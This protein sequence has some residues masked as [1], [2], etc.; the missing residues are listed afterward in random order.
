MYFYIPIKKHMTIKKSG[1]GAQGAT[2]TTE[3]KSNGAKPELSNL[4]V[5]PKVEEPK[6][7]A[8]KEE[9][10]KPEQPQKVVSVEDRKKRMELF[11]AL[12]AKH[13]TYQ[14]THQKIEAFS[15]GSDEHS[16]TLTFKDSKG[17]TFSTGNPVILKPVLE[18]V[19]QQIKM[20]VGELDKDILEFII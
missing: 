9:Q 10:P 11:S 19:R 15:I 1:N 13:E 5:G 12:V 4:K 3:L 17:A 18:L 7:E 14:D 16:Q 20:Q 2:P 8:K 6:P